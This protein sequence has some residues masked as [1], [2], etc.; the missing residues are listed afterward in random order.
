M[1]APPDIEVGVIAVL[2]AGMPSASV[3]DS[4]PNPR[5]S[6]TYVRVTATGGQSRNLIQADPRVL[7]ECWAEDKQA[8]FDAAQLAW[9]RLW[10]AQDSFLT[11]QVYATRIESTT[12]VNFPDPDTDSPRYQFISTITASLTEVSA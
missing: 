6:G 2:T 8:A 12:P 9:A 4:V 7:V 3:A 1:I 10:A 11:P 5:P